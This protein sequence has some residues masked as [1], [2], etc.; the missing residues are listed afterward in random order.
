MIRRHQSHLLHEVNGPIADKLQRQ[1][2]RRL[3]VLTLLACLPIMAYAIAWYADH[4]WLLIAAGCPV[5]ALASAL[6][7]SLRGVF[8]FDDELLDEYQIGLRNRAYK[9]AYGYTMIFL[10]LVATT[11]T[12][13]S[14]ERQSAFAVAVF[15]FLASGFAPRMLLAWNMESEYGSE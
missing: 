10:V 15:A 9:T 2:T 13:L 1:S 14:L 6:N 4:I 8:E 3:L 11:A 5:F 12:G 7:M